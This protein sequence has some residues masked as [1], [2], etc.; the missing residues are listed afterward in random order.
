MPYPYER[1][2]ASRLR[3]F[4]RDPAQPRIDEIIARS[5]KDRRRSLQAL[6]LVSLR[7]PIVLVATSP[8]DSGYVSRSLL[9]AAFR[10]TG[11]PPIW[12]LHWAILIDDQY[13]EL[14]RTP[15]SSRFYF[16]QSKWEQS[17]IEEI[18]AWSEVV[19]DT[20]LTNEDIF[21]IGR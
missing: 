6:G 4:H 3:K 19:G 1:P 12:T 11:A 16:K 7:R 5:A 13:F 17:K 8:T 15:G 2:P 14:H 10:A 9:K 20:D 21:E 18:I